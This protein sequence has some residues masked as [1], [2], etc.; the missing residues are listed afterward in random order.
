MLRDGLSKLYIKNSEFRNRGEI[1]G[2]LENFHDAIFALSITLLLI[3]SEPP[4]H[5][6]QIKHFV[7]DLVPFALCIVLI[8]MTWQGHFIFFYRYGFQ[9]GKILFLDGLFLFIV[10]FYV[11]PLKFLT[12]LIEIPIASL[13]NDQALLIEL[14]GT[15]SIQDIGDLMIIY[16]LGASSVFLVMALMYRYA[17]TQKE[18]IGLNQIEIFDTK[19]SIQNNILMGSVPLIS[20]LLAIAFRGHWR[21]GMISGF[22]YFLYFPIMFVFGARAVKN[23]KK[24]LE[25]ITTES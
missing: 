8:V 24:L 1:P 15:I 3:S 20:V 12:R 7:Y 5:F 21:A 2:R 22:S 16:G 4:T 6:S 18:E 14:R 19:I 11:Y 10:L 9:K 17:L 13:I 23:R 25:T